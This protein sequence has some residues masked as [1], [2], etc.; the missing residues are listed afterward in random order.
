[1][2]LKIR[3]KKLAT[4]KNPDFCGSNYPQNEQKISAQIWQNVIYIFIFY[5]CLK[6]NQFSENHKINYFRRR[7]ITI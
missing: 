7:D 3:K 6:F 4:T 1:M 2:W 5:I